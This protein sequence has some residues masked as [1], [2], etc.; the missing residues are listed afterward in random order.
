MTRRS[1]ASAAAPGCGAEREERRAEHSARWGWV[2]GGWTRQTLL[3]ARRPRAAAAAQGSQRRRAE[4]MAIAGVLRS[5]QPGWSLAV[6]GLLG[7][8]LYSCG[9]D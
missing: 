7:R 1:W 6:A 2:W 3:D 5:R 4:E 9:P 8:P